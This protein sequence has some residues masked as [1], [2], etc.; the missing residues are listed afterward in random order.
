MSINIARDINLNEASSNATRARLVES[1]IDLLI[2]VGFTKTT[3][4]AVC[5]RA[6]LTR[7]ALNH[8]FPVFSELFVETLQTIYWRLL[9][10]HFDKDASLGVLEGIVIEGHAR[11]ILPEFK[12]VIELWLASKNDPDLGKRL[13]QA[14]AQSAQLFTPEIVLDRTNKKISSEN[15]EGFE[16][17]YRTIFEA[18][19]GI[20]LGRA[21]GGGTP[22]DHESMVLRVLRDM[23]RQ[24]DRKHEH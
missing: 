22:M 1:T 16:A 18:L 21:V 14:I 15:R 5:R 6:G 7:G 23:A 2:K 8:H 20:G 3:G 24:Y 4:V 11:I 10:V 19:I 9:D 13:A 17:I 12:A